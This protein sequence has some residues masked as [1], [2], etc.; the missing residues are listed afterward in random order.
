VI[1]TKWPD[2]VFLVLDTHR[3]DRL[4]CYGHHLETTPQ[5]DSLAADATLFRHAVAPAQWTIPS[6]SSMFTG[7]YPSAHTTVQSFSKLPPTLPTLAERLR[8]CG[9]H[10]VAFCNNPLVGVV[11]NGL[12][13]GFQSFLNYSGLMT[14]RPNQAGSQSRL[15]DRYRQLFKRMIVTLLSRIQDSFA[16]S[17]TLLDFSFNP[18]MVPLWQT[19]LSFKGNTSRSLND[20]ARLLIERRGLHPNQPAFCF[21]NLMGTHM[22]Y[23]PARHAMERFA[24]HVLQDKAAQKYLQRFNTDIYGWLAPLAGELDD[25]RKATIDS[26][27]NAEAYTQDEHV[28][29]FL[30]HLR[31]SGRLDQ[32]LLVVV[33][34]HGDHLGEKQLLGHSFSLY[35]ELVHVPL[36]VRDPTGD[37]ARGTTIEH[38]VSTRRLFHSILTAAGI[39]EPAEERLTLAQSATADPDQGMVF[40]EGVPPQN[41]VNLLQRREPELVRRH[42]CDQIRRAVW[43][44]GHKLIQTGGDQG[45]ELYGVLDD[46]RE[47]C[48][49]HDS[50]PE[51]V[52][53][54]LAQLNTFVT[55]AGTVAPVAELIDEEETDPAISQRLRDLG[56]IE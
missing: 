4:S 3:A 20:A 23:H 38:F 52:S 40:A 1:L 41:I 56:Y 44:G 53:A 34:D 28:G 50:A 25:E 22:P 24:P 51:Q 46:P 42:R 10:T 49:L 19:A 5:I 43:Q 9:F 7:L 17:E 55:H 26:M 18:L 15:I 48:N 29:K 2:I 32:T 47:H 45:I 31:D 14:S 12:R 11:N 33:A 37:F 39:A 21:I 27:Y 8:D 35:N 30:Q 16:R 54:L 13:R 36:L 6:H